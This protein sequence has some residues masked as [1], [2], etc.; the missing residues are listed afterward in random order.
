M[1]VTAAPSRRVWVEQIMGMPISVH[2]RGAVP[3][4]TDTARHGH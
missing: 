4:D 3:T 1:T 2:I